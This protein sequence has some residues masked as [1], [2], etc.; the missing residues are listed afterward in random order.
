MLEVCAARE[1]RVEVPEAK[2]VG[3]LLLE[4]REDGPQRW[5]SHN[6]GIIGSI[7][8]D[9]SNNGHLTCSVAE[10][11]V[12]EVVM[13]PEQSKGPKDHS[14]VSNI[15]R[16]PSYRKDDKEDQRRSLRIDDIHGSTTNYVA[17]WP[18]PELE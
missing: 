10:A 9:S 2:L 16:A 4:Q 8:C 17:L 15:P 7:F 3:E 5:V 11:D 18:N 13:A 6:I 14:S 12:N 1:V